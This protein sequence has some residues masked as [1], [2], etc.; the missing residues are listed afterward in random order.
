VGAGRLQE[1]IDRKRRMQ[2]RPRPRT[3]APQDRPM[4]T[5]RNIH[6]E[7]ADRGG[8]PAGALTPRARPPRAR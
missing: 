6:D 1:L 3:G 2:R 5:A 4:F 7:L 8:Q